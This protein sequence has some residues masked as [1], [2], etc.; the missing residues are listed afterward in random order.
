MNLHFPQASQVTLMQMVNGSHIRKHWNTWLDHLTLGFSLSLALNLNWIK[1]E[2]PPEEPSA[3]RRQPWCPIT[4][5]LTIFACL[6]QLPWA[7]CPALVPILES[8]EIPPG[9][10]AWSTHLA[11]EAEWRTHQIYSPPPSPLPPPG[12]FWE[13]QW[14]CPASGSS[15]TAEQAGAWERT[16]SPAGIHPSHVLLG[17]PQALE[18]V[19]WE[20][21]EDFNSHNDWGQS[22]YSVSGATDTKHPAILERKPHKEEVP[23]CPKCQNYL[24]FFSVYPT[25][26]ATGVNVSCTP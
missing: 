3:I 18:G 7:Q 9:A 23:L 8:W 4:N 22:H 26:Y 17:S 15:R 20:G 2:S 14:L 1:L 11:R 10:L 5:W 21:V 13:G 16:R 24:P 12:Q 6:S 25:N 19:G